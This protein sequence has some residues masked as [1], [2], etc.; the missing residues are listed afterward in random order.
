MIKLGDI[1]NCVSSI[2]H[3]ICFTNL[4]ISSVQAWKAQKKKPIYRVYISWTFFT[5]ILVCDHFQCLQRKIPFYFA[6]KY[7]VTILINLGE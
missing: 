7:L 4:V 6:W 2:F 5:G 1:K 3:L